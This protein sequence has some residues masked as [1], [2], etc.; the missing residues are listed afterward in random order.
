MLLDGELEVVLL[1]LGLELRR[2]VRLEVVEADLQVLFTA[3]SGLKLHF[4]KFVFFDVLENGLLLVD[5]LLG[6]GDVDGLFLNLLVDQDVGALVYA[7]FATFAREETLVVVVKPRESV[8]FF[9]AETLLLE[10]CELEVGYARI[11]ELEPT[12]FDT[13]SR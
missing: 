3:L 7:E 11:V 13:E 1:D 2:N 4:V 9:A 5:V 10:V 8:V 6:E 12:V